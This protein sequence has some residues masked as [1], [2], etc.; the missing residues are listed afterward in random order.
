MADAVSTIV[1]CDTLMRYEVQLTNIGD[2]TGESAVRK[3]VLGDLVGNPESLALEKVSGTVS[4]YDYVKLEFDR[5]PRETMLILPEGQNECKY[6]PSYL[7]DHNHDQA[8]TTGDILLTTGPIS[9]QTVLLYDIA[10]AS[11]GDINIAGTYRILLRF[12]KK[13]AGRHYG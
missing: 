9:D 2:G 3:I 8:S 6:K 1:L 7:K 5:T 12:K 11:A 10:G 13:Y 4:G